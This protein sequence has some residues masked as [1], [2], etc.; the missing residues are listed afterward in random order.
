MRNA[1]RWLAVACAV[2]GLVTGSRAQTPKKPPIL[3]RAE[4]MLDVRTGRLL[5]DQEILI[6][7]DTIRQVGA[8]SKI[9]RNLP[10]NTTVLEM[11]GITL[12]PGLIDSHAHF[13]GNPKDISSTS[14]LRTSSAEGV[15]W[16]LKNLRSYME[17]G[18]T[19]LRN[20][21]EA[22]LGYGQL[23]LRDAIDRGLVSGPRIVSAGNFVSLSGGHGDADALAPDQAL[24]RRPNIADTVDQMRQAV[25]HDLKYGADWI[26]LNATGGISDRWSDFNVQEFSEEQMATAVEVA[27]RAGKK[28]LAHAEGTAGIKAAVRAGVD[29]VEHGTMLDDE[30]AALMAQKGTWLIPTLQVFQRYVEIGEKLEPVTFAKAKA[31]LKHQ[32]PAFERALK[33]KVKIA[34]GVDDDPDYALREFGALVNGGMKPIQAIQ[35][36]TIRGAEL[37]GMADKIGSI[38]PGKFADIIAVRG[39]PTQD[40]AAMNNVVFVMKGGEVFK[41]ELSAAPQH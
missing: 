16:G 22:D 20:A 34:Y 17:K 12:L 11:R 5:P 27:H 18:F 29:S 19:T 39:D 35:A 3:I 38:E 4:R 41:N 40:I 13:L 33:H 36:A 8:A 31:I 2:I 9:G 30:G 7:G 14:S 24:P 28:V 25:R 26:K 32:Q 1:V 37:C 6:E 21:G 23:A 15:L 10:A